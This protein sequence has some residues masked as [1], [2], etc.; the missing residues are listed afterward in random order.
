METVEQ[1]G[2]RYA[3]R[4]V[5]PG[6]RLA[7]FAR[8]LK[9][10][11]AFHIG[12]NYWYL[13]PNGKSPGVLKVRRGIIEEIGIADQRLTRGRPAARRFLKSFS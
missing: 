4:G 11:A 12:L 9:T 2:L 5:S 10:G 1:R 8:R 13:A 3:L 6:A 7:T